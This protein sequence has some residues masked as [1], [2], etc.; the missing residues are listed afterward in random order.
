MKYVPSVNTWILTASEAAAGQERL[1]VLEVVVVVRRV[2]PVADG[3]GDDVAHRERR[4]VVNRDD[5][6]LVVTVFD[7][8]GT[9]AVAT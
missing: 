1:G 7:D 4:P 8:D 3:R 5:A 2:G 6:R 9:E